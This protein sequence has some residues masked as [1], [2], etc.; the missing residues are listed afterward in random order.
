MSKSETEKKRHSTQLSVREYWVRWLWREPRHL[1]VQEKMGLEQNCVSSTQRWL[2][3]FKKI[4]RTSV[5]GWPMWEGL[6][7]DRWKSSEK[8]TNDSR[9]SWSKAGNNYQDKHVW[10]SQA[11]QKGQQEKWNAGGHIWL[12]ELIRTPDLYWKELVSKILFYG[13]LLIIHC[14]LLTGD[15]YCTHCI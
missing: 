13:C 1:F 4:L 11:F 12:K 5:Q 3:A 14:W 9:D 8:K 6:F 15:C 7:N 10:L 2:S